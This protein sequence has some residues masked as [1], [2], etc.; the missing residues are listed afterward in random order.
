[1]SH[2]LLTFIVCQVIGLNCE[3]V[4]LYIRVHILTINYLLIS[5]HRVA[6]W[7]SILRQIKI[8]DVLMPLLLPDT[9]SN[10]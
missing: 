5:K 3:D 2:T 9:D 8:R 6:S 7:L 4:I 10:T 1:M